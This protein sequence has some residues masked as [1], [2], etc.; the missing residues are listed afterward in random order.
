MTRPMIPAPT[1]PMAPAIPHDALPDPGDGLAGDPDVT[2]DGAAGSMAV[3]SLGTSVDTVV[4]AVSPRAWRNRIVGEGYETPDQLLANP[5]N[6]RVHP[7]HQQQKLEG[8]LSGVGWIQR[9]IVNEA[10]GHVID[11]HARVGL[12]IARGEPRVPVLYVDLTLEEERLV[13]ATLDPIGALATTDRHVLDTLLAD[14]SSPDGAVQRL[15]DDLAR[16]SA[17]ASTLHGLPL[18][19]DPFAE[20]EGVQRTSGN[21]TGAGNGKGEQGSASPSA[22]AWPVVRVS[23]PRDTADRYRE[24]LARCAGHEEWERFSALVEAAA[25]TLRP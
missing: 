1:R 15:L 8:V 7:L 21:E 12:A 23:V 24:I 14:I 13:L 9:I 20:P 19:G 3:A 17:L 22:E 18:G 5:L 16:E 10:T 11:G 25:G 4:T 2:T 6:W